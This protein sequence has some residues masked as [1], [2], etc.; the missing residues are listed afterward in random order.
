MVKNVLN[1]LRKKQKNNKGFT[2][3]ELIVVIAI[4]AVLVGILAPQFIKYVDKSRA[5]TDMQNLQLIKSAVEIY[6]A[7]NGSSKTFTLTATKTNISIKSADKEKILE[8]AGLK[9]NFT[10]KSGK[11]S[12]VSMTYDPSNNS[13]TITGKNSIDEDKYDLSNMSKPE[14]PKTS[15][16]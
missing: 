4:M 7:D 15:K 5:S 9:D 14:K 8:N 3:V 2:L 13:W 1:T 11:W 10:L 6:Y 16:K 12:N